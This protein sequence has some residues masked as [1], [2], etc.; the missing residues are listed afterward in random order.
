VRPAVVLRRHLADG[1]FGHVVEAWGLALEKGG[2]D[3][4]GNAVDANL[5]AA[6]AT[7]PPGAEK[8]AGYVVN[9]EVWNSGD[10]G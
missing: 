6:A 3:D 8:E 5:V 9:T 10:G 1:G 4:F 7:G 2:G